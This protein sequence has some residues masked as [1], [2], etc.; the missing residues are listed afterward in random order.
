MLIKR[1]VSTPQRAC[2]GPNSRAQREVDACETDRSI[3]KDLVVS[4]Q[5]LTV[6]RPAN[7]LVRK[8]TD[9]TIRIAY[10][11]TLR[12]MALGRTHTVSDLDARDRQGQTHVHSDEGE[13][14]EVSTRE[15]EDLRRG[16]LV[17][18]NAKATRRERT[19]GHLNFLLPLMYCQS[20]E[21]E[22]KKKKFGFFTRKTLKKLR[23]DMIRRMDDAPKPVGPNGW[24]SEEP[25]VA[26][27]H[28]PRAATVT[29]AEIQEKDS[30]NAP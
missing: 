30:V 24:I 28:R 4:V 19:K 3:T 13:E 16:A 27:P 7:L 18:I 1:A 8:D 11:V 15:V 6:D 26:R 5:R 22:V 2:D 20:K 25:V 9:V 14:E 21:K 29:V 12:A 17:P 23:P 10:S